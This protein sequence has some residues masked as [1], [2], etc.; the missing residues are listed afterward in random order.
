[1]KRPGHGGVAGVRR[2][3][4]PRGGDRG[5]RAGQRQGARADHRADRRSETE[6]REKA[7]ADAAVA[8]HVTGKTVKKV[9]VAQGKLVSVVVA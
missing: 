1:M 8:A 5:A 9:I 7:L 6:I 2:R 4:C 3:R